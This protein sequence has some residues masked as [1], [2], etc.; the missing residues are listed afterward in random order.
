MLLAGCGS[1]KAT[2]PAQQP[3]SRESAGIEKAGSPEE[4]QKVDSFE[5]PKLVAEI[6]RA[7]KAETSGER[8]E[9]LGA[10]TKLI[11]LGPQGEAAILNEMGHD[12]REVRYIAVLAIP[13]GT[14]GKFAVDALT[15]KL[16]DTD[17][18]VRMMAAN[19]LARIGKDARSAIFHLKLALK[20]ETDLNVVRNMGSSLGRLEREAAE[21]E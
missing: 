20:R 2:A 21:P 4:G 9:A 7:A 14:A 18:D 10:A 16:S 11:S 8:T 19:A 17:K 1:D 13:P 6:R 12:S 5:I 15:E 3:A